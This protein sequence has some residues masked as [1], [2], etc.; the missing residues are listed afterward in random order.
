MKEELIL[1]LDFDG[2]FHHFFPL[3]NK[4]DKEN[5]LF[6]YVDNVE[7]FCKKILEHYELKIV[8]ATSWKEKFSFEE[9]KG[10]FEDYPSIFNSCY[11]VTPNI[12]GLADE[13]Y[14]WEE[15]KIWLSENNY[16]G[17]YFILD[18]NPDSWKE[19]GIVNSN[20]IF[21]DNKFDDVEEEL[22]FQHLSISNKNKL[23]I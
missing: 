8:F 11:S 14:K 17:K 16:E 19:K 9:L 3:G 2:V 23:K 7:N 15:T 5:E 13:G 4:T 6:Y 12:K 1:F 10:F 22:A 18:D 21:C 20:L